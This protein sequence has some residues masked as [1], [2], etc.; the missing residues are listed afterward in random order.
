[1]ARQIAELWEK[2]P[3][4]E[5]GE[6]RD[7]LY[8]IVDKLCIV[9]LKVDFVYNKVDVLKHSNY[10]DNWGIG[11]DWTEFLR[12]C[13]R[14]KLYRNDSV[15]S[16]LSL[17]GL[18]AFSRTS[19]E[20]DTIIPTN[21]DI[22]SRISINLF[23]STAHPEHVVY[24]VIKDE[25]DPGLMQRIVDIFIYNSCDYFIYLDGKR[26][27][28]VMFS[29]K[30]GIMGP[31]SSSENYEEQLLR[32]TQTYVMAEDRPNVCKQ[33][34]LSEVIAALNKDGHHSFT[35][36][37]L[38]NGRYRR[39]KIVYR[40]YNK[41]DCMILLYRTDITDAY[42]EGLRQ[43]R[44]LQ[45]ALEKSYTDAL[46]RVLN[47]QGLEIKCQK[48]LGAI[49]ENFAFMFV[50]LDNFKQVNDNLGH[51]MGD[52]VLKQV[53]SALQSEVR[54]TDLV[55]RF[56]GDE[57]AILF[58]HIRKPELIKSA[59]KRILTSIEQIS[60]DLGI[61]YKVTASIGISF[62]LGQGRTFDNLVAISDELSYQSKR[63]GK[64]R[65][66]IEEDLVTDHDCLEETSA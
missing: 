8:Y 55:G 24:V 17:E 21:L 34:R 49:K 29:S 65:M 27:S 40:Y 43:N 2:F 59:G 52:T 9:A 26:N 61:P 4:Y 5:K 51:Q 18:A 22:G 57:F 53:A 3:Y 37:L 14:G 46:T 31:P 39:K 58:C 64:N 62:S 50:D 23:K 56:G 45:E 60:D 15:R 36:G 42:F 63:A 32:C 30:E 12:T 28:Y 20:H 38:E 41:E 7:D 19:I 25:T 54:E 1:M 47:R 66:T 33:L 16:R 10:K 35:L 48:A 6:R 44:E 11:D 13:Y